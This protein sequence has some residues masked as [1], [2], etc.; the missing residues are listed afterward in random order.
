MIES[1]QIVG[2]AL[3]FI[4]PAY[5]ANGA[6]VVVGGGPP[7]DG[8]K[9]LSDGYR[10]FGD[11]KTI[12]GFVL[13]LLVGSIAGVLQSV[14]WSRPGG[15]SVVIFLALG[16]LLGD[17][18]GSFI[19]RRGGLQRGRPAP[20]LD[21]LGFVVGALLIASTV[22]VPEWKVIVTLLVLTPFI[23]LTTN[24]AGYKMGF[25]PEPY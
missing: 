11:G 23:H 15:W 6:P 13:G 5:V 9:K 17:L 8:G 3:W 10:I 18:V 2:Q 25:K 21:Q 19:K 20:G 1:L 7:I 12:R 16:A 22:I 14:I 4:F 24:F